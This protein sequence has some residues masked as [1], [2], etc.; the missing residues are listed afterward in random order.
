MGMI[1]GAGIGG[2]VGSVAVPVETQTTVQQT[3]P[4]T[5]SINSSSNVNENRAAMAVGTAVGSVV[6]RKVEKALTAKLAQEITIAMDGGET[7][8]V[9][10]EYEEPGFYENERVKILTGRMGESV[11]YHANYD[12][13]ADPETNAYLI[14][15]DEELEG[16]FEP[17]SW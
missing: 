12:P 17:V 5:I 4:D 15:E 8:S 3:G 11:V 9:V 13:N 2:A 7:I 14:P 1:V 16:D 6:G 10:Q